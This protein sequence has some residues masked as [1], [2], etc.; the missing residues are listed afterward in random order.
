MPIS[1][2]ETVDTLIPVYSKSLFFKMNNVFKNRAPFSILMWLYM[3]KVGLNVEDVI[4]GFNLSRASAFRYCRMLADANV[5]ERIWDVA[6]KDI[7]AYARNRFVISEYGRRLIETLFSLEEGVRTS[8][9]TDLESRKEWELS[10][11]VSG[12]LEKRLTRRLADYEHTKKF[13]DFIFKLISN[14][15]ADIR[16]RTVHILWAR[17]GSNAVI[18]WSKNKTDTI[19]C[20]IAVTKWPEPAILGLLSHELS[21]IALGTDLHD[22]LQADEDVISRGLGHYLAIERAFTKKYS[23]HV[24]RDG[25][26]RYL[27][28]NSIRK[29]LKSHQV[30]ELDRL[31]SEIEMEV[32][33]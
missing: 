25:E 2:S 26:D 1:N 16:D 18:V 31:L 32:P 29:Q 15:Y 12:K 17:A 20:N 33:S 19:R 30:K 28:Y 10:E 24:L 22:E 4:A 27:G 3:N 11:Q 14:E 13:E 8:D 9:V 5:V 6:E 21:H 7:R 23:D